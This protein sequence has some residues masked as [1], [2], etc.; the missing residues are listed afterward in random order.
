MFLLR[1]RQERI[2]LRNTFSSGMSM[3]RDTGFLLGSKLTS[4]GVLCLVLQDHILRDLLIHLSTKKSNE[5]GETSD[6]HVV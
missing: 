3:L 6:N 2:T 4:S 1:N 5:M